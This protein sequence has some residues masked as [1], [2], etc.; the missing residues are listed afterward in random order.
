M[1][2]FLLSRNEDD[3]ILPTTIR[4]NT[5]MTYVVLGKKWSKSERR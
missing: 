5:T 3:V 4:E 1:I 2:K